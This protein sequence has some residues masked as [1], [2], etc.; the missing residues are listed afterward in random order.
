MIDEA[1]A[2]YRPDELRLVFVAEAPPPPEPGR[3][4]YFDD[5]RTGDGL[6][7]NLMRVL[8]RDAA[9]ATAARLRERKRELLETFKAD[10]FFLIDACDEPMP[11]KPSRA[12]KHTLLEDSLP[13]LRE[14]AAELA[15]APGLPFI[16]ISNT[17]YDVCRAELAEHVNVLNVE[18]IDFPAHRWQRR[19]RERLDRLLR[20]KALRSPKRAGVLGA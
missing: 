19:F 20:E 17:V 2:R 10:G 13:V 18:P 15:A 14:R 7:L 5:V 9:D 3:F 11:P 12:V 4:F 16:L 8:Y 6:F 1:R